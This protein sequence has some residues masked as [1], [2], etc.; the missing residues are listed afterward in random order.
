MW[1]NEY[2][3]G[4]GTGPQSLLILLVL[5]EGDAL[6]KSARLLHFDSDRHE[7]WHDGFKRYSSSTDGVRFSIFDLGATYKQFLS[8]RVE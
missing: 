7:I 5:L 4:P 2:I 3:F 6:R 1:T 8:V